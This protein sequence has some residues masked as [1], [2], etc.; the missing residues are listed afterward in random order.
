VNHPVILDFRIVGV[1]SVGGGDWRA[2]PC[3][4]GDWRATPCAGGIGIGGGCSD[5]VNGGCYDNN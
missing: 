3:A 2:T 5:A 4:G 1:G